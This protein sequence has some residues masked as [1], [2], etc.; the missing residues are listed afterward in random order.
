M[1]HLMLYIIFTIAMVLGSH[2]ELSAAS[3]LTTHC[4]KDRL[5][6]VE[7]KQN[8]PEAQLDDA[9]IAIYG[10]C[11][12]RPERLSP[13]GNMYANSSASRLSYNKI[14]FLSSLLSAM[15][16]DCEPSR[17]ETAPIHF[18]V[19]SKY[20]VICLRHLLC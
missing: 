13:S 3:R 9:S 17:D 16:S 7:H 6:K 20:Y 2:G 4:S 14:R 18:D 5:E 10:A 11:S 1:R 15:S 19:A 8:K 12:S